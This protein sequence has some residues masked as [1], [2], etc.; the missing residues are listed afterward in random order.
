MTV[1]VPSAS[2]WEQYTVIAII[3][4]VF[5]AV[6]YGV[7]AFWR[8]W[9]RNQAIEREYQRTIQDEQDAKREAEREQQRV[10]QS[11]QNV[12]R[13]QDEAKRDTFRETEQ[14]KR[15]DMWR[16]FFEKMDD[17]SRAEQARSNEILSELVKEIGAMTLELRQHDVWARQ[18][19]DPVIKANSARSNE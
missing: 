14:G 5:I 19:L 16:K 7:R 17:R 4:L 1:P 10:W 8:E 13:E 6:A 3:V 15:D 12:K 2:I 9:A 11:E 18:A